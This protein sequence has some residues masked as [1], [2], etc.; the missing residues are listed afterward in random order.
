[1]EQLSTR[2]QLAILLRQK[3]FFGGLISKSQAFI[4]RAEETPDIFY[5]VFYQPDKPGE[6]LLL[7]FIAETA[8]GDELLYESV[9]LDS[10][11]L[12]G[13]KLFESI[14]NQEWPTHESKTHYSH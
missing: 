2:G 4:D 6:E 9:S 8:D 11:R 13:G 14:F 7:E 10:A 3:G 12:A 1:M 5:G